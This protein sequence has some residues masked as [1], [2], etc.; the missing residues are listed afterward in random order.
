MHTNSWIHRIHFDMRSQWKDQKKKLLKKCP[1]HN[2]TT[3]NM[4]DMCMHQVH[5]GNAEHHVMTETWIINLP[6][7]ISKLRLGGYEN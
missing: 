7:N 2:V 3:M 1:E 5:D 6:T 4:D